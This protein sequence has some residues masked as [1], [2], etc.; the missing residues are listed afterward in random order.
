MTKTTKLFSSIFDLGPLTPKIYSPKFAYVGHWVSHSLW[1]IVCGSTTFGQGAE[2]Q[3]PT[4]LFNIFSSFQEWAN[5]MARRS[6]S[7][8]PSVNFCANR[9]FSQ[10]N[11]RI[12]TKLAH[13]GLRVSMHPGC[14]QGQGQGQGQRLRDTRTFLEWATPSLTVWLLKCY[15]G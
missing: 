10:A 2:I 14:A 5:A 1:V 15:T 12:A 4:G 3:S 11:G 9:F 6:S 7:V 13:D 8:C